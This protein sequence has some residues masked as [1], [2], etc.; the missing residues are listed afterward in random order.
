MAW[1]SLCIK[2]SKALV[3][4]LRDCTVSIRNQAGKSEA[5]YLTR[6][7]KLF[8]IIMVQV[9]KLKKLGFALLVMDKL[10]VGLLGL[11]GLWGLGRFVSGL[12]E[13]ASE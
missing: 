1:R 7:E 11:Q 10:R 4:N 6:N 3:E 8:L 9:W 13:Q 12:H 5:A 2:R